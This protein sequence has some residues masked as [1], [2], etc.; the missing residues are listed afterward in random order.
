[1]RHITRGPVYRVWTVLRERGPM[2]AASLAEAL[3]ITV[4]AVTGHLR[5]LSNGGMA[6]RIKGRRWVAL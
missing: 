2:G 1:M 4:P 5:A 6:M 3:G